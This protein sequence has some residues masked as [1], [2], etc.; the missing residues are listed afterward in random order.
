MMKCVERRRKEWSPCFHPTQRLNPT[1]LLPPLSSCKKRTSSK[2]FRL[3]GAIFFFFFWS[4]AK[5]DLTTK[6]PSS[7]RRS[8]ER[9][10]V[11]DVL[12]A[13]CAL[14]VGRVKHKKIRRRRPC[15]KPSRLGPYCC[16]RRRH[17][18]HR[19]HYYY[20]GRSLPIVLPRTPYHY[21]IIVRVFPA[22]F[23]DLIFQIDL[24]KHRVLL[25]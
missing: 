23:D 19:R 18:R 1:I 12:R 8:Q 14:L 24:Y 20:F 15:E 7:L 21:V 10:R 25:Q 16:C 9:S 11:C 13:R 4:L 22:I 2:V 3:V 6:S 17:H 5:P